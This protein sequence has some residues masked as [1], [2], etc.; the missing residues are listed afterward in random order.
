MSNSAPKVIIRSG[1]SSFFRII[2]LWFVW[3]LMGLFIIFILLNIILGASENGLQATLSE[4]GQRFVNPLNKIS[5]DFNAYNDNIGLSK[6]AKNMLFIS[7]FAQ[8]YILYLYI[9]GFH[10][11]IFFPLLGENASPLIRYGMTFGLIFMLQS[12]YL[13]IKG[14]SLNV[15]FDGIKDLFLATKFI[16]SKLA[17]YGE[18]IIGNNID[19]TTNIIE[20]ISNINQTINISSY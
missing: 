19:N 9:R 10:K 15:I 7:I 17:G 16:I 13:I 3:G 18:F 20:N 14:L 11:I 12:I 1:G 4:L 8:V 2:R 6:F 5:I